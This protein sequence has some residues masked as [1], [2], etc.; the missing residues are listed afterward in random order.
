M[1]WLPQRTNAAVPWTPLATPTTSTAST[2]LATPVSSVGSTS[3]QLSTATVQRPPPAAALQTARPTPA[4]VANVFGTWG[5]GRRKG[6]KTRGKKRSSRR[7][8]TR[9]R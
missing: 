8:V 7:R 5:R 2:V 9:R 1:D 4:Q 6:K 3:S